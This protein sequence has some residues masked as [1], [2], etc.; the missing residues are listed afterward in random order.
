[1]E[2]II[3]VKNLSLQF[4]LR[5]GTVQALRNVS[6]DIPRGKVTAL[7]GESG[8]G[9]TTLATA[10]MKL[11]SFPGEI[12]EVENLAKLPPFAAVVLIAISVVLT[13]IAGLFPSGVA[14]NKDPVV[15]LRTE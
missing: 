4:P 9:K 14:A 2:T 11:V 5:Y 10:L 12:T 3:Q 6:I 7:V 15:A 13:L 1:M 8:S